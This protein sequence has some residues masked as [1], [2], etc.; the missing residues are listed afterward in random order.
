ME[1][2]TDLEESLE[3]SLEGNLE[4][5]IAEKIVERLELDMKPEYIPY[6][7]PLFT[8]EAKGGGENNLGLD[9]VDGLELVVLIYEMWG[10]KVPAEDISNLN[11]V[12]RIAEYVRQK[13]DAVKR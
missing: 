8:S 13:L 7:A 4:K 3:E 1:N 6:T 10:I 11:T 2:F 12:G 5:K 9:S